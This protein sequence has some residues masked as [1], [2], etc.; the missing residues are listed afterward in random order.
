MSILGTRVLRTE[1]PRF[2]TT[3][4]VYTEDLTDDRLAAACHVF[5]V[6][7]PV[8]HARITRIDLTA[9][10]AAPGVLAA[11]TGT[12]LADL[13]SI[14]PMM[15][16]VLNAK[17]TRR[18]LATDKVRFVGD[19]VAAVV[20]DDPYLGE[21]AVELVDVDYDP[22]P[23]VVDFDDALADEVIVFDDAGTNV[24]ARFGNADGLKPDLFDGCEVVVTRTFVNQR[25]APAPMES[26]AAAAVWGEDGRLTVWIPN[27]GAQSSRESVASILGIEENQV[28]VITPDV[29]GAFGAK[30]GADPEH[31]VVAWVARRLGRPARWAETRF[32]NLISMTHGP[33]PAPD[34]H[35]RRLEG[36]GRAGLP[37]GDHPGRRRLP[38]HR[39]RAAVP[40]DHDG[41]RPLL[42]PERRGDRDLDHHHHDTDGRLPRR[43]ATGGHGRA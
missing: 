37:A 10:L 9:A 7:S 14:E 8:A 28:R 25:V 22:L 16:G 11:F 29:G 15:A 2:L 43:R 3:G 38:G 19:P 40:D 23:P 34:G 18:P 35:D 41:L 1:D 26:R 5:F 17:M 32:E 42:D 12:D 30:F 20:T 13:P 24:V 6:R 21:D 33:G 39:R 27:Q 31:A 36:R 4:G